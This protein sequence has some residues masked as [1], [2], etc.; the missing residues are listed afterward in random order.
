M[1][2][3]DL[4]EQKKPKKD[5]HYHHLKRDQEGTERGG[6]GV[7]YSQLTRGEQGKK[8]YSKLNHDDEASPQAHGV[9]SDMYGKLK[10]EVSLAWYCYT[11]NFRLLANDPL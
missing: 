7:G 4:K 10:V 6:E 5:T 8:E 9:L 3:H 11:V 2:Q 1:V